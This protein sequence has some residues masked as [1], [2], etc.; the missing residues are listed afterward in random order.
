ML[1]MSETLRRTLLLEPVAAPP[2][3]HKRWQ[4]AERLTAWV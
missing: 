4:G 3:V 1:R 2:T